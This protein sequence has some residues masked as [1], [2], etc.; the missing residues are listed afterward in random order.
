MHFK[1]IFLTLWSTNRKQI[2]RASWAVL[3][4]ENYGLVIYDEEILLSQ[5]ADIASHWTYCEFNEEI[6][7]RLSFV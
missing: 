2:S 5:A 1:Y 7:S 6:W 3:C 4:N